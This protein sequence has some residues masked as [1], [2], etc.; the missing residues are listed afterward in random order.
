MKAEG[1]GGRFGEFECLEFE[2][3]AVDAVLGDAWEGDIDAKRGISMGVEVIGE[4]WR[5][6]RTSRWG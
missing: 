2:S 6:G 3:G 1:V 5:M 4:G